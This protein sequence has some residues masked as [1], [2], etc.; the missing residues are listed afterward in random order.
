MASLFSLGECTDNIRIYNQGTCFG[1]NAGYDNFDTCIIKV[2]ADCELEVHSFYTES[3]FDVLY[4]NG[5]S[6]SG[7]DGPNGVFVHNTE[8][9]K[10]IADYTGTD[11]GFDI[12]GLVSSSEERSQSSESSPFMDC[13]KENLCFVIIVVTMFV[14][15]LL[16]LCRRISNRWETMLLKEREY[17]DPRW[18]RVE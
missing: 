11:L 13:V 2:L 4:V 1:T 16:Y 8:E 15:G 12:C 18:P 6:Y 17:L 7:T 3:V 9:I 14:C 10:F 5:V